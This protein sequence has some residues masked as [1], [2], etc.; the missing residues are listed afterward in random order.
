MN[1]EKIYKG[2]IKEVKLIASSVFGMNTYQITFNT[3][4]VYYQASRKHIF[5][6]AANDIILF[7]AELHNGLWVANIIDPADEYTKKQQD[8]MHQEELEKAQNIVQYHRQ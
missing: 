1:T 3:G 8:M 5:T 4:I 7:N 2:K 6:Y